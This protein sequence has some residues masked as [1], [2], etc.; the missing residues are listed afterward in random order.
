MGAGPK[1]LIVLI[2]VLAVVL[3]IGIAV[4]VVMVAT[5]RRRDDER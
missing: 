5:G 4:G 1:M 2:I 3:A